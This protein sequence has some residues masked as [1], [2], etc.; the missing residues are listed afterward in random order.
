MLLAVQRSLTA[1]TTD[2]EAKWLHNAHIMYLYINRINR[3]YLMM[4]IRM[5]IRPDPDRDRHPG[6][7]DPDPIEKSV[8]PNIL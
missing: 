8:L 5:R 7:A 2:M 6:H 4:W 3:F 1:E